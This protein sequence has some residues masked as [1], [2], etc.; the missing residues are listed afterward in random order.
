MNN[1]FPDALNFAS[2]VIFSSFPSD[3]RIGRTNS[4]DDVCEAA[5]CPVGRDAWSHFLRFAIVPFSPLSL[6]KAFAGG[7]L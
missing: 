4:W 7:S 2:L 5:S 3:E 1:G 6:L